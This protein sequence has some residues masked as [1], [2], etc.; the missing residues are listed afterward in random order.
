MGHASF[1]VLAFPRLSCIAPV[2]FN[3]FHRLDALSEIEN[4]SRFNDLKPNQVLE[5]VGCG[6]DAF[7]QLVSEGVHFLTVVDGSRELQVQSASLRTQTY[8]TT[9]KTPEATVASAAPRIPISGI[10]IRPKMSA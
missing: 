1:R 10:P 6:A 7:V 9:E 2:T 5:H 8:A 4:R 3:I